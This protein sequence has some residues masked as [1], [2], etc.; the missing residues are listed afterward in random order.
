MFF[1]VL[2]ATAQKEE[3]FNNI[4]QNKIKYAF[5]VAQN[6]W[7]YAEVGYQEE[8][9]SEDLIS[10]LREAGFKISKGV[11]EIPTAF[12]AE[13][14]KGGPIIGILGEYDALPGLSQTNEAVKRERDGVKSGH[15]CGHNLFGVASAAAA[16][17]IKKWLESSKEKRNNKVL[18]GCPA[19][20]GGSGKVYMVGEGLFEDVDI[21][22]HWHPSGNNNATVKSSLANKTGKFRFYG[23]SSHAASAP[24]QAKICLR[25]V[26]GNEQHVK[27]NERTR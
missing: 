3:L 22:L 12:I 20:E 14:S 6:I 23:T 7:E 26:R 19:E 17:S 10:L 8:K 18:C 27:L 15:A 13:Y 11:A 24:E 1:V 4:E 9:S 5:E 25:W 2:F 21:V 16:I